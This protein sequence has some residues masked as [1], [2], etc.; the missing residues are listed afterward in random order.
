MY[1]LV[2]HTGSSR[3]PSWAAR[4]A[5]SPAR[6]TVPVPVFVSVVSFPAP[7]VPPVIVMG[8]HGSKMEV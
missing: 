4:A 2:E 1:R 7:I 3:V 5:A 8:R 6:I